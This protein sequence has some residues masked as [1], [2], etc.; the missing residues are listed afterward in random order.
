MDTDELDFITAQSR[1]IGPQWI[2]TS[3]VTYGVIIN[4]FGY[5]TS[6][7]SYYTYNSTDQ[8]YV[9]ATLQRLNGYQYADVQP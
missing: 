5:A 7:V 8:I 4:S 6:T 1:M 2:S 9:A 3:N